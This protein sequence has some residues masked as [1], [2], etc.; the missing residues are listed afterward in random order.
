M[1][2]EEQRYGS[3]LTLLSFILQV[4]FSLLRHPCALSLM[5]IVPSRLQDPCLLQSGSRTVVETSTEH[6][7]HVVDDDLEHCATTILTTSS[8]GR[9]SIPYESVQTTPTSVVYRQTGVEEAAD[10][11]VTVVVAIRL[12]VLTAESLAALLL[13]CELS[14]WLAVLTAESLAALLL[15]CE[16]ANAKSNILFE[17]NNELWATP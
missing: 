15:V 17:F 6:E 3:V 8:E 16:F 2:P 9:I 5:Q 10:V 4:N 1:K 7:W 12:P 14:I 13:E 11:V